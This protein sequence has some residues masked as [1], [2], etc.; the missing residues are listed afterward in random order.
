MSL[1]NS[2]Y[3]KSTSKTSYILCRVES[4]GQSVL[5]QNYKAHLKNKHPSENSNDLRAKGQK[6]I[7]VPKRGSGADEKNNEFHLAKIVVE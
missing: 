3:Y 5:K 4:C 7:F 1:P 6:S 2:I